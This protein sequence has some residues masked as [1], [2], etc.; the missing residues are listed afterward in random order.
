VSTLTFVKDG[1]FSTSVEELFA[2]HERPGAFERLNPPWR[3]VRILQKPDSIKNGARAKIQIPLGPTGIPWLLEHSEYCKNVSFVD[4]QI[5]GPFR[6]WK[7][8]HLFSATSISASH[9]RD[10][11]SFELPFGTSVGASFILSELMRLFQHRH[12]ILRSDLE[13]HQRWHNSPK[14]RILISG[15]SG[16]IGN[17]LVAFL[18]T[19]GHEVTRLVRRSANDPHE[20]QWD[21]DSGTI[22]STPEV[23]AVIHLGGE[24]I[25]SGRWSESKKSRIRHSRVNST[26]QLS[27]LI[28]NGTIKT[29]CALFASAIGIY[30]DRGH[31]ELS[32]SSPAGA[33]FL[34]DV[35]REWEGATATA[36][37]SGARVVNL[38]F[39][40]VLNPAGGALAK[41]WIPFY[42]GLGG[43][44]GSGNH[45]MS[46]ISLQD[47]LG[48]VE[49]ALFTDE[50]HGPLNVVAP[51]AA[52]NGEFTKA[53]GSVIHRP[54]L[55]PVPAKIL[56]LAFGELAD[57]ALLA[58]TRAVPTRLLESGYQFVHPDLLSA[59]QFECGLT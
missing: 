53:F 8:Q 4:T 49:H 23:D 36:K 39:G 11:I 14:Q 16:F 32:E 38:R 46:W 25:S 54:T 17:A 3:P 42:C 1:S 52:T 30:G 45:F 58:S 56:S 31:V 9:L 50:I 34:A 24:D 40:V 18:R 12:S 37:S 57:A 27:R 20:V 6:S 41:M 33:G 10:E 15:S 48:I 44:L 13:L 59:L 29:R 22:G 5:S 43:R 21:P 35:G 7:H 47:V 2:W 19:G 28:A 51:T 55:F 26:S